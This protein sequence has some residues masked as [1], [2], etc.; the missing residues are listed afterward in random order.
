MSLTVRLSPKAERTLNTLAKR[1]GQSRSEIV[2]D[3]IAQYEAVQ[4]GD[5][6]GGRSYD[7][8]MDVIGVINLGVRDSASTTGE[9]F[10]ALVQE[11]ARARRTR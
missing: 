2:R 11:H 4:A 10:T 9:Q 6:F 7:A 5:V 3:A 1:R 8:W